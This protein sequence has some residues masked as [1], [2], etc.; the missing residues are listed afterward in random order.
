MTEHTRL[1]NAWRA[2]SLNA[3]FKCRILLTPNRSK[4]VKKIPPPSF[5]SSCADYL[6]NTCLP[7][8]DINK[9]RFLRLALLNKSPR[10][11]WQ[12][13]QYKLLRVAIRDMEEM[14]GGEKRFENCLTYKKQENDERPRMIWHARQNVW[15]K[16]TMRPSWQVHW[17]AC[18]PFGCFWQLGAFFLKGVLCK[19]Y[20]PVLPIKMAFSPQRANSS[21]NTPNLPAF[22]LSCC[23]FTRTP[24]CVE[25]LDNCVGM[26][27]V[28]NCQFSSYS[29]AVSNYT[30]LLLHSPLKLLDTSSVF[31]YLNWFHLWVLQ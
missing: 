16:L 22:C 31:N 30:S 24:S 14:E 5:F 11:S 13:D 17:I 26:W 23:L 15:I 2:S 29:C 12:A 27:D 10:K 28:N 19:R 18:P 20:G 1:A 8:F 25:R 7:Y 3:N 9:R 6:W 21:P 4:R